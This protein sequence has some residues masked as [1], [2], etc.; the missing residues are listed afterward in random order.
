MGKLRDESLDGDAG[1]FSAEML[2]GLAKGA[3][4][5]LVAIFR[6]EPFEQIV[7]LCEL[8]PLVRVGMH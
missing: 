4:K 7:E 5:P 3:K 8:L 6:G 1:R 2:R